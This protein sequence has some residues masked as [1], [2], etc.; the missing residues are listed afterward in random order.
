MSNQNMEIPS[1]QN[2]SGRTLGE[3]EIK[4]LIEVIKSGTLTSTKGHFVKDLE[5]ELA[6]M[7]GVPYAHA[8]SSG[9]NAIHA[10]I[11][12]IDPEPGDEIITTSITDMGALAPI[13]YQSA[14]PVFV[15]VDPKTYNVTAKSIE[16]AISEKTK[17]I[18][19]THLFGNPCEMTE[20]MEV[21]NRHNIPVIEDCA[22]SYGSTHHGKQLGTIGAIGCF[23]FQQGKHITTGEGGFCVTSDKAL[24]RRIFLFINKAWGYGDSNA[25]HYFLAL[26]S[27]MTEL[28]GAVA[29]AQLKKLSDVVSIRVSNAAKLNKQLEGLQGISTPTIYEGNVHTYWKYCIQVHS[30]ALKGGITALS[31][32]LRDKGIA[33]APHYIQKP[34]FQCAVFKDQRTF[35]NSR[36]PFT[37]ARPE[38]VDYAPE[39]FPGTFEAL[40]GILVIAWNEKYTDE[41]VQYIGDSISE[42]IKQLSV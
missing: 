28:Q 37:L 35:G 5:K 11:C 6:A 31:Q 41:H 17:A 13:V 38:A 15:D 19:V 22:Q 32:A 4:N 1:D 20:I 29:L 33:V 7:F 21:A 16:D 3:E 39:K 23:S 24:A 42:A 2:A 30:E 34:A 12:A 8:C 18:I 40:A 14:I 9:S 27:R 10:A 36:F 26:N 25:D